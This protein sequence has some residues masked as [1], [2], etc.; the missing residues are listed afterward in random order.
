MLAKL[1]PAAALGVYTMAVFLIQTPSVFIT[2]MLV[3]ILLPTFAHVQE[4]K[5]RVNRILIEV[6]SWL[7][8]LGLP[9]MVACY[10]CG[11]SLLRLIYGARYSAGAG[12][13][14][15]A[16][17]VVFLSLLNVLITNVFSG[18]GRPGLHRRAVAA[19]AV[20][21]AIA[22]YPACHFLG[23]VG[24]QVAALLAIIASY[25]LQVWRMR[26]LTGLDL[27]RYGRAFVPAV[28]A[29]AGALGIGLCARFVGLA[30]KPAANIAVGA[31]VC[32]LAYAV[33]VPAFLRIR[34]TAQPAVKLSDI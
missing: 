19:S 5:Q 22:V 11:A 7:I 2:N 10:L 8:L 18:M 6:T 23:L 31:G 30:D 34:Q 13:F 29:S 4:N 24:G 17:I 12:P 1:Y 3:Q 25:G 9:A 14:A 15:V 32:V 27:L 20:V 16:A 28:L 26:D 21:M 33:C